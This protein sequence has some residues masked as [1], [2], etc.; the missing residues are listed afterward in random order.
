MNLAFQDRSTDADVTKTTASITSDRQF[1]APAIWHP[2][3]TSILRVEVGDIQSL[4][5]F[6]RVGI[7]IWYMSGQWSASATIRFKNGL[8]FLRWALNSSSL[9]QT[10]LFLICVQRVLLWFRK[11]CPRCSSKLSRIVAPH[12]SPARKDWAKSR[13]HRYWSCGAERSSF[14]SH[15]LFH[16]VSPYLH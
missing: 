7:S 9:R 3:H 14:L 8:W 11:S 15:I 1:N 5:Q 10:I 6:I 2:L 12:I 13:S 16:L 4:E